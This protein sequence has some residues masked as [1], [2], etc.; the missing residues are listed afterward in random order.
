M[1]M[2]L[3]YIVNFS[4][5]VKA[6]FVAHKEDLIAFDDQFD[7][8]YETE[9]FDEKLEDAQAIILP[10]SKQD[11]NEFDTSIRNGYMDNL[12]PVLKELRYRVKKGIK[13]GDIEVGLSAFGI[14]PFL[15]SINNH[16]IGAFHLAYV[17]CFE[18]VTIFHLVLDELGFGAAKVA[19]IKTIHDLAWGL[20][21]SKITLAQEI[22]ELSEENAAIVQR[23]LDEDQNVI[24]GLRAMAEASGDVNLKKEATVNAILRNLNYLPIRKP[25]NRSIKPGASIVLHTDFVAKNILQLT[26]LT[27]VKVVIGLCV[28]KSDVVTLGS[29]LPFNEE[30]EGKK[31]DLLGSGRFIKLTNC[32]TH[33][34]AK[35]RCYYVNV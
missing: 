1:I 26:L 16:S 8:P 3:A 34:K 19:S 28:L 15:A 31:K 35:V 2:K 22:S 32:D 30:W 29:E 4:R 12:V 25:Y 20:E 14:G 23:C 13:S 11:Q 5:A 27:D 18:Q 24:D 33:K 10:R 21:D 7:V 6:L 17:V 9:V